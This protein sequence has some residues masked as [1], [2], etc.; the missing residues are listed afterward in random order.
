MTELTNRTR[1]RFFSSVAATG[2]LLLV[3]N[4]TGVAQGRPAGAGTQRPAAAAPTEVHAPVPTISWH[5]CPGHPDL[6][7]AHVRVPLDYD[8][9]NGAQTTLALLKR[10]ASHPAER[11]GSLFV[12][13]GGPGGSSR[14]FV[15]FA[16]QLLGSTVRQ[17]F[18]IIGI[19]PRGIGGSTRVHCIAKPDD[20]PLPPP[21]R[22]YFPRSEKQIDQWLAFD[23]AVRHLCA[24][25]GNA[26]LDHMSTADTA[27]DMDL[28]RQAVGDPLLSYYGISYGS[29]LGQTYAALF[30]AR[31]RALIID[32]VLDP[33]QWTTGRFGTGDRY[34]VAARL[35][36]GYGSWEALNSAFSECDRVGPKT[37]PWAYTIGHEWDRVVTKLR[38]GAVRA[39]GSRI[40]YANVHGTILGGLYSAGAYPQ[41]MRFIDDLY[42]LIFT[43]QPG[44]GEAA[45]RAW[46]QLKDAVAREGSTPRYGPVAPVPSPRGLLARD[47]ISPTFQGVLCSDSVNPDDP[48][49]AIAS[50]RHANQR[51]PGFGAL[52]SWISSICVNWP[53]SSADA[54]RG[55]WRT[56]TAHPIL[57]TGNVHDPATP[58]SGARA[59]NKLFAGSRMITVDMWGHGALGASDCAR[60]KWDRY[61]V[62]L[63]LP[64]NGLVCQ[65]DNPLFPG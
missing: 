26:I 6:R 45:E 64:A 32:G 10:P 39:G 50:A 2:C 1:R 20:P 40:T 12:N 53:G 46:L 43:K 44:A 3:V 11:I 19:D 27:R 8:V 57:I 33:V 5:V 55:P 18:D 25:R 9:P 60:S 37:C 16:A 28:I 29:I 17:H 34:L 52:W 23:K 36:S 51:G 13:P 21:A 15:P 54:Y 30:P 62:T 49:A 4:G 38:A 56:R 7:C 63:R 42:Q 65:P 24:K 58:I 59:A 22:L 48:R 41:I 31:V 35:G 61:L 14:G 47:R